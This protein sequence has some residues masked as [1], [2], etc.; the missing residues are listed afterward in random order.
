MQSFVMPN[1]PKATYNTACNS[2]E[3]SHVSQWKNQHSKPPNLKQLNRKISV[4]TI[5]RK[6]QKEPV[7]FI[8]FRED[9]FDTSNSVKPSLIE[10]NSSDYTAGKAK[11]LQV[12]A[13]RE[14]K[15]CAGHAL[16]F[17]LSSQRLRYVATSGPVR[18]YHSDWP[19]P[20]VVPWPSDQHTYGTFSLPDHFVELIY[21]IRTNIR[22]V[23]N[24]GIW[25]NISTGLR[26]LF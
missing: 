17:E 20:I 2:I 13:M 8:H 4:I 6:N 21:G 10:N 11:K 18:V 12:T 1:I 19:F 23:N 15:I 7:L 5:V 24:K 9:E 22:N 26:D 16:Q 14:N 25:S 3:R